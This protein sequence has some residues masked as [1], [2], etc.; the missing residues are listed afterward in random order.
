[1]WNPDASM[2]ILYRSFELKREQK[3]AEWAEL[4]KDQM[5][6]CLASSLAV[7]MEE[8]DELR[9]VLLDRVEL[10]D[11]IRER[12]EFGTLWGLRVPCYV[13]LPKGLNGKVCRCTC[14][15]WAWF[16]E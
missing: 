9:P 16:R 15:A 6:K 7:P 1:M 10:E 3:R 5:K 11:H 12:I 4:T 2:E 8:Q 14:S 13:L